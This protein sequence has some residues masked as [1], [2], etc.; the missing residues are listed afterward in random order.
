[1]R[2]IPVSVS[3]INRSQS[4]DQF[5]WFDTLLYI[6]FI[7]FPTFWKAS[8]AATEISDATSAYSIAVAAR[9]H[10]RSFVNKRMDLS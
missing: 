1:M 10:R 4:A 5:K 8:R 7:L 6:V 9:A 3:T 2:L